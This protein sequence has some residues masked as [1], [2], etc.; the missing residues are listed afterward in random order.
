MT[1]PPLGEGASRAVRVQKTGELIANVLRAQIVRGELKEGDALP[2]EL[3]LM[4]QFDVSRPTLREAFRILEAESLIAIRRGSRGARVLAPDI[5][6]AAR[7][8]GL[9]LQVS[10][11]TIADVYEARSIIEPP[12]AGRLARV[13][14]A[15][16]VAELR[17]CVRSIADAIDA[18]PTLDS[19]RF[20]QL[21]QRLHDLLMQRA[22]N[23]TL[24][25]QSAV[26]SDVVN[27]H[28][29]LV[30]RFDEDAATARRAF[31]RTIR[32]YEKLCDLVEAGD[33]AGAEAHW[34]KHMEEAGRAL[35]RE[36]LR[37]AT[38]VDLFS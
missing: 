12:A 14:T 30:G 5:G 4:Q 15:A 34:R 10:G 18:A 2:S 24:A 23:R 38:V 17:A 7:Y 29:G 33:A 22:G 31:A 9:L 25:I 27:T 19:G 8:V 35:L 26:L 21:T 11:T 3:E 28:L 13:R 6:V 32:S 36:G 1:T 16:D 37:G 20:A